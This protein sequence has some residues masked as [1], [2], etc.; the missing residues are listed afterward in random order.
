MLY[1]FD[2]FFVGLYHLT[3]VLVDVA[4]VGCLK[5]QLESIMCILNES[6]R[7]LTINID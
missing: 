2:M 5:H 4:V 3:K 7:R 1:C 6:G